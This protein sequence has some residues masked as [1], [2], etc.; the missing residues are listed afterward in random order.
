MLSPLL[1]PSR[2]KRVTAR[3]MAVAVFAG[4]ST[5]SLNAQQLVLPVPGTTFDI[6]IPPGA[7]FDKAAFRLWTPTGIDS[8]TCVLVLTP[9]SNGDGRNAVQDTVW[10]LFA[11][12]HHLALLASQLTDKVHDQGFIEHYV[13]VSKGS[14][15]AMLNALS[16]LGTQA[17]HPELVD[18]PLLLWGMSAG[19]QFNYE[20]V[21]WK[22]ERVMAFVV[23]KGGIYYS[24]LL[25]LAARQVPGMLFV[26][27]RDLAFRT[28][29]IVGLFAVN[30]RAGAVWALANEPA[31]GHI[32]GKSRDV[33]LVFFEDVLNLR[34]DRTS[35]A[36]HTLDERGGF[37]GDLTRHT[38]APSS[39]GNPPSVPTAWLPTERVARAW[40]AMETEQAVQ[41]WNRLPGR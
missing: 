27:G 39:G 26:G 12:K 15:Q 20:F 36:L 11:I 30:R 19:G 31:A 25:P 41:V 16:A 38:F 33:A 35:T 32:V 13:D 37:I 34:R 18:A 14:G 9:G 28:N 40:Q 5:N 23:N 29:T 24:A 17:K 1:T 4:L 21:A 8:L 22:P 7:N 2:Y 3:S 6:T 10:Q